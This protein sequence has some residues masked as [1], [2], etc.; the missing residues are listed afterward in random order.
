MHALFPPS[1]RYDP[2]IE[3]SYQK[4]CVVDGVDCMLDITDTAGQEEYRCAP[5]SNLRAFWGGD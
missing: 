2:T 5:C 3:D 1:P 4:Q